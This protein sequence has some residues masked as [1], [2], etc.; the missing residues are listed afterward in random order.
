MPELPEVEAARRLADRVLAGRRLERVRAARDS[1][2]FD[3]ASPRSVSRALTGRT[4][5]G[6]D[7]HGKQF[8]LVM[9]RGPCPIF[10][11]GMTGSLVLLS[12]GEPSPRFW[13][14]ELRADCGARVAIINKRRLGRIRLA[15]D[16][17]RSPHLSRLGF[18]PY[19]DLPS[20]RPFREAL[21]RRKAPVKAVLLDQ[22][23]AAGVGNWIA[24][25]VLYQAGIAPFRRACDLA[26]EEIE[27]L[28]RRLRSVLKK[29]VSVDAD[30]DRFPRSWLFHSRWGRVAGARTGRGEAIEF[31]TVGGRTTAWV[32]SAQE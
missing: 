11:F 9:D 14:L 24:D 15:E 4:V 7:R 2:V 8:W 21:A 18:D 29:A 19:L 28:R 10:H 27:T 25:E 31:L 26:P 23:F 13:K 22:S 16:P 1:L 17:R 5:T 30:S 12:D 6:T 20:P 3:G 32:P